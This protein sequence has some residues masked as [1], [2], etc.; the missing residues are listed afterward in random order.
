[1][2][3]VSHISQTSK[4]KGHPMSVRMQPDRPLLSGTQCLLVAM[5]QPTQLISTVGGIVALP[6]TVS[7]GGIPSWTDKYGERNCTYRTV[8]QSNRR[9]LLYLFARQFLFSCYYSPR[10]K[11]PTPCYNAHSTTMVTL[12]DCSVLCLPLSIGTPKFHGVHRFLV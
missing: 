9:R 5:R 2:R 8:W 12:F 4:V 6:E 3:S 7:C 11:W 10:S 1:M